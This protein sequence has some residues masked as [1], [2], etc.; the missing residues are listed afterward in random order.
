MNGGWRLFK[1]PRVDCE[2]NLT[3][4]N[5]LKIKIKTVICYKKVENNDLWADRMYF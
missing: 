5:S 1:T 4:F 2:N 3:N